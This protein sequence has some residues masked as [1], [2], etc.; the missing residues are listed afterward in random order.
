MLRSFVAAVALA[1]AACAPTEQPGD[2]DVADVPEETA[3]AAA[4]SIVTAPDGVTIHYDDQG[5]GDVSV[6]FVH[7]WS[8]D[9][10]YWEAQRDHFAQRYR[11]VTVDLAGHGD[12]GDNRDE[13]TMSA[14]GADVAAVAAALDLR[15][16]VLVGH[17]M[18]GPVVLEAARLLGD[19]LAAVVGVDTL[20][21]VEGVLTAD[22]LEQRMASLEADFVG[23][24]QGIVK[25]MFVEQSDLKLRD[26][27]V[28]DMSSAPPR[29]AKSAMVGLATFKATPAIAAVSVPFVLINSDYRPTR[30]A[31]IEAA[32]A[33]FQYI[34]M[35]GVGHFLMMEDPETFNT[36][37]N[38]V[39]QS[40]SLFKDNKES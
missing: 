9:R 8:C 12:S 28:A 31:P 22:A 33:D 18:G 10:G 36:H 21:N 13:F 38:N 23:D 20:R 15:N 16:V 27:V 14:F 5:Q 34:E 26:E 29:V 7:G 3:V 30:A 24:V 17:S 40:L 39:I 19:R 4:P 1:L 11:V 6:V 2:M 37:L 25:G 35:T 32:A